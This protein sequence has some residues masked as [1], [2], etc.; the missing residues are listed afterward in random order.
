MRK[1]RLVGGWVRERERE[2]GG[3]PQETVSV[4]SRELEEQR[5]HSASASGVFSPL[6]TERDDRCGP[7]VAA[8]G[9]GGRGGGVV[10]TNMF[11]RTT[12]VCVQR[13]FC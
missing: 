1:C 8:A 10:L 11:V 13:V 4:L 9:L 6:L 3:V 2:R 7:A 12:L 5:R